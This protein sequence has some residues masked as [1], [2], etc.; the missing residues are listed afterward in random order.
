VPIFIEAIPPER[1]FVVVG[2]MVAFA[3]DALEGV[4]ARQALSSFKSRGIE[5][6]ISFTAPC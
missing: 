5:F 1:I 2:Y 6:R 4:G 3:I